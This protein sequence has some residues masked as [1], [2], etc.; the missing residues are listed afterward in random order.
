M[1]VGVDKMGGVSLKPAT[2]VQQ[3]IK[4]LSSGH[5]MVGFMFYGIGM[6]MW[7]KV[8]GDHKDF[9][10]SMIYSKIHY[11]FLLGISVFYFKEKFTMYRGVGVVVIFVGVLLFAM[12]DPQLETV[13]T[14]E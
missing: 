6:L 9:M 3:I 13:H 4:I 7:L 12:G 10:Q 5:I 8:L 11:L 1:K 14:G 2:I